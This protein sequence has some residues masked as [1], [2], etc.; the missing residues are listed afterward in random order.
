MALNRARVLREVS[1]S[2]AGARCFSA[3]AEAEKVKVEVSRED[4]RFRVK[5]FNA[6]S[7]LGLVRLAS[8]LAFAYMLPLA[9]WSEGAAVRRFFGN[10]AVRAD[11]YGMWSL[12]AAMSDPLLLLLAA[13]GAGAFF[14]NALSF[15]ASKHTEPVTMAVVASVKQVL[16]IALGA[17]LFGVPLKAVNCGGI[18]LALCSAL[19]Y[20]LGG[21]RRHAS[22]RRGTVTKP[23]LSPPTRRST[24]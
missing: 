21:A 17:W 19:A 7:P 16:T 13:S 18:A 9:I 24:N 8:P 20:S 1:R 15:L 2:C 3:A 12:G 6:I 5:T 23:P 11:G 14:L 22:L 10:R 4:G